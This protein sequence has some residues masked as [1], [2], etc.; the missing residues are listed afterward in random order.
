MESE[1]ASGLGDLE[2]DIP[3]DHAG[4]DSPAVAVV[5]LSHSQEGCWSPTRNWCGRHHVTAAMNYSSWLMR[6]GVCA[7]CHKPIVGGLDDNMRS[8]RL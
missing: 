5:S 1:L 4:C 7:V 3:C 8:I 2:F 6:G